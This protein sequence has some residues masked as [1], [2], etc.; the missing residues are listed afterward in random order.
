MSTTTESEKA[1]A[2]HDVTPDEIAEGSRYTMVVQWSPEDGLFIVSVPE[3][4]DFVK[5]HGATPAEA[6]EMGA[7]VVAAVLGAHRRRGEPVPPPRFFGS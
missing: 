2:V 1:E 6:V 5:T 4:G 3:L 7:E